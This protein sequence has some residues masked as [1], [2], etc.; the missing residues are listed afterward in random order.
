MKTPEQ[1]LGDLKAALIQLAR[2]WEVEIFAN[3]DEAAGVFRLYPF[4]HEARANTLGDCREQLEAI[5]QGREPVD[6]LAQLKAALQGR[7]PEENL[8][9]EPVEQNAERP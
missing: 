2:Q 8:A 1:E 3:R 4:I 6:N 7:E 9:L 5:L